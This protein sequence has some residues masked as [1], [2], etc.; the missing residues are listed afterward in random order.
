MDEEDEDKY[1]KPD[2]KQPTDEYRVTEMVN[3]A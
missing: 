1:Q 2:G 3:R